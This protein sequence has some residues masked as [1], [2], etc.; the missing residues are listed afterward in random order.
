MAESLRSS[1]N[2]D[3]ALYHLY[4]DSAPGIME[5]ESGNPEFLAGYLIN[6]LDLFCLDLTGEDGSVRR[7]SGASPAKCCQP[8][9]VSQQPLISPGFPRHS[10]A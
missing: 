10:Q 3:L 2:E 6:L 8:L 9:P 1:M 5:G 7:Y 4:L